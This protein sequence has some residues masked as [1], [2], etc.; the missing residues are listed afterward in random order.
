MKV[1]YEDELNAA[2]LEAVTTTEGTVLIIAG[3]G[4]GKTKTLTFRTAYLL[5]NGISPKNILLLTFTNK[6]ANEMKDRIKKLLKNQSASEITACTFHSFCCKMLRIYGEHIQLSQHFSILTPSDN[7]KSM[8]IVKAENMDKYNFKGFPSS[9]IITGDISVAINKNIDFAEIMRQKKKV[10]Y[11]SE[12]VEKVLELKAEWEQYKEDNSMVNYDDMMLLFLKLLQTKEDIRKRIE[13]QFRYIMV[14]EYQ[15]T[16]ILQDQIVNL[17]R[18]ENTNLCVVGDDM[19]SLYSFRGAE[20]HNILDFPEKHPG[21]S[22]IKLENNYRS[23]QEILNLSNRVC[24]NATE[25]FAKTLRGT[26]WAGKKPMVLKTWNQMEEADYIV[27]SIKNYIS[28]NIPLKEI[29]V[30]SRSSQALCY[31]E[32]LLNK[33]QIPF[34]KYGGVKFFDKDHIQDILAFMK[35]TMN[36]HDEIAWFRILMRHAGIGEVIGNSIAKECKV[37]GI[38]QLLDPKYEKYK[39]SE[40]L[41]ILYNELARIKVLPFKTFVGE[42][43]KFYLETEKRNIDN[44]RT[45]D[46]KRLEYY[47]IHESHIQDFNLLLEMLDDF[48]SMQDFMDNMVLGNNEKEDEDNDCVTLSTIHS[49]KGLEFDIVYVIDCV[50]LVFPSVEWPVAPENEKE[51]NEE[52]RC[53]YVAITRAKEHLFIGYPQEVKRYNR[54]LMNMQLSHFLNGCEKLYVTEQNNSQMQCIS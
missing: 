43:I 51:N 16:N 10:Y 34:Q 39:Y 33:E 2:Q 45:S 42:A 4:T 52:L 13:E 41:K 25:G 28:M 29:C 22:I 3:A 21:C 32:M 8:D 7:T 20:V 49:A 24:A 9:K 26:H 36:N 19:Q 31:I 37:K 27:E 12:V 17:L 6:A 38:R 53:F 15:D 54:L 50:D 1:K 40:E 11:S 14:D 48:Q 18:Q 23:N 35:I 5:E 46:T 30:L 44:M 47:M